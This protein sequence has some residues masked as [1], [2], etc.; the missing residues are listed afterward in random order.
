MK[1]KKFEYEISGHK[2]NVLNIGKKVGEK[3]LKLAGKEFKKK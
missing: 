2:E 3:L 1:K